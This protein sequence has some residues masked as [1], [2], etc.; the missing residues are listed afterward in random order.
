LD[1]L[2]QLIEP[3]VSHRANPITDAFCL[4]G[5]RR[6][7]RSLRRAVNDGADI[8]AREDMALASLLSGLALANA[9]L[10]AV[11]GFAAPLGGMY[12]A[13]HGALCAALLPHAMKANLA[14]LQQ[15]QPGG[16]SLAR[17]DRL[18]P[19]L[20]SN[21]TATAQDAVTW[22]EELCHDL[23]VRPLSAL[24]VQRERFDE[25]ASKASLAS[26]MKA[27][28]IPLTTAE[29]HQILEAAF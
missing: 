24:T 5:L 3:F 21:P 1:A 18:G 15:R 9:G 19:I 11:H 7:S 23:R 25:L 13:P 26:S 16:E 6:V 17:F 28:P 22:V 4:E 10:G 20:T 2:T 27:N 14:A 29:L 8:R 12:S